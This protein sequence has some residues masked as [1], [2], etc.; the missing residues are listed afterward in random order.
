MRSE[1]SIVRI[2]LERCAEAS[3]ALFEVSQPGAS[4]TQFAAAR[5]EVEEA[6]AILH[7]TL[8]LLPTPTGTPLDPHPSTGPPP[9]RA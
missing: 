7:R 5:R 6:I 3:A 8:A 1:R 2:W 9:I 4:H